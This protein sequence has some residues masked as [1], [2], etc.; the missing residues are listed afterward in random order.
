MIRIALRKDC[1]V[2]QQGQVRLVD[3]RAHV[4]ASQPLSPFVVNQRQVNQHPA[5]S[6]SKLL[7]LMNSLR[8]ESIATERTLL[9]LTKCGVPFICG[10]A[11]ENANRLKAYKS[12][13]VVFPRRSKK[14]KQGDSSAEE[15]STAQQQSSR[16]VLPIA[17]EKPEAEFVSIPSELKVDAGHVLHYQTQWSCSPCCALRPLLWHCQACLRFDELCVVL[18]QLPAVFASFAN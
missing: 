9:L 10:H 7:C 3:S 1:S 15:L 5:V 16:R 4:C 13:L 2:G 17:E 18:K 11:Q 12:K 8:S 14:P 6:V